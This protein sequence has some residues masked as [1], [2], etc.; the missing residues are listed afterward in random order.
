MQGCRGTFLCPCAWVTWWRLGGSTSMSFRM[1]C[2]QNSCHLISV[3]S[4]ELEWVLE[5]FFVQYFHFSWCVCVLNNFCVPFS[6]N[7]SQHWGAEG[8]C[9]YWS[10]LTQA[11]ACYSKY[12]SHIVCCRYCLWELCM[13]KTNFFTFLGTATQWSWVWKRIPW[14]YSYKVRLFSNFF[15]FK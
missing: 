7:S 11:T 6:Q 9:V 10:T 4:S 13:F 14:S 5:L 2:P 12:W 3:V 1:W 15:I 8:L